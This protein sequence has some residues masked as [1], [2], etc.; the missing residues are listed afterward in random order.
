MTSDRDHFLSSYDYEYPPELVAQQ[1]LERRSA[2]RMMILQPTA[3][4]A[5]SQMIHAKFC[6]LPNQVSPG[7]LIVVNNTQ[8]LASRLFAKKST[9]GQ[10]EIFLLKKNSTE[11][12]TESLDFTS[13][14]T[15]WEAM[16][17]P[18][19]GIK[20]GDRLQIF[21]RARQC[22][23]PIYLQ[24]ISGSGQTW[25]VAFTSLAEETQVLEEIGEVPL[26]PY[27]KRPA[28]LGSDKQRYQTCFAKQPGAVAAPTA[29]LHFDEAMMKALRAS[30]VNVATVTLHVGR[31]TFAPVKVEHL[32]EHLMHS[33]YFEIPP[34]TETLLQ[35]TRAAG[36]KILAVGTTTLRALESFA[37]S[38]FRQGMTDLFIRPGYEFRLVDQLLTNFHQPKST[39]LMLVAALTGREFLF[40][41][42]QE[43]IAKSYRLFSYGDCMLVEAS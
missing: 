40:K 28:P 31:G 3:S 43:A 27:I 16:I 20:V 15:I 2:S 14:Q 6:D 22:V 7:D 11:N 10:V 37:A 9:G 13:D 33:E 39:L 1:P 25:Q 42:Y 24:V 36:G 4:Q 32:D 30:G 29:G 26:P 18:V 8:V 23:L 41:A 38:G 19:R 17:S 34:E 12:T 35:Q 21:S 5:E